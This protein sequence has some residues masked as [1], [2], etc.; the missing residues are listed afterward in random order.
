M[1]LLNEEKRRAIAFH[2][3]RAGEFADRYSDLAV[4][5]YASCFGYSRYRL[6]RALEPHLPERG[7]GRRLLDVG[8]GTGHHLASYRDRGF[9]V[10]GV[11]GSEAM[12]A[13]ARAKNP[14]AIVL[15]ADVETLPFAAASFDY[16]LCI[17][18]LRY[19][20]DCGPCLG[21][22]RRVLKP[23]GVCLATATP[24]LNLNGY[25]LVNR[26]AHFSGIPGLARVKQ[27]FHTAGTLRRAASAAGFR[28]VDVQGV[29]LGPVNWVGRLAPFWLPVF[30]RRWER[31]DAALADRGILREFSNMFLVCATR[32]LDPTC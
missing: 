22:I 16:V 31:V 18:V 21:E 7:D 30:L 11:D 10:A 12:I 3:D 19:L 25:W 29:Y 4:D 20:P 13:R 1:A 15:P 28:A 17:E 2:S 8:C 32:G 6:A 5:P 27:Y 9:E 14:G 24:R 23:G 26:A